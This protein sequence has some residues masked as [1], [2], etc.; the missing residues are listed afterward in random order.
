MSDVMRLDDA[1]LA[2]EPSNAVEM[3]VAVQCH[4]LRSCPQ[5]N[6]RMLLESS[7]QIARHRVSQAIPA[8]QQM[9]MLGR[10]RETHGSLA[11]GVAATDDCNFVAREQLRLH[12]PGRVIQ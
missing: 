4:E 1:R 12:A 9:A 6:R 11:R 8:D 5:R 2:V 7:R 3:P 10:F